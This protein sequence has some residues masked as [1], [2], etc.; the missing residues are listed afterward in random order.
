MSERLVFSHN[1]EVKK[2]PNELGLSWDI[3]VLPDGNFTRITWPHDKHESG[4][5][6]F[7]V[8]RLE[9]SKWP[10]GRDATIEEIYN[11]ALLAMEQMPDQELVTKMASD[12]LQVMGSAENS[13]QKKRKDIG[14]ALWKL[15]PHS[16]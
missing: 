4:S 6:P 16:G 5:G 12:A 10:I 9:D 15:L 14:E 2:W 3:N 1:H 7:C 8:L 13:A 11:F